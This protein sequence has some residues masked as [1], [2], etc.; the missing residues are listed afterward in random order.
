MKNR[1]KIKKINDSNELLGYLI[2][3]ADEDGDFNIE[4][5]IKEYGSSRLLDINEMLNE[6]QEKRYILICNRTVIHVY[7][8][9]YQEYISPLKY[10]FL[11][12]KTP[13][14]S[15]LNTIISSLIGAIV[16]SII[17]KHF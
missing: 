9:G 10:F 17:T 2:K 8:L 13:A 3:H 12:M 6:L 15:I 16:G 1:K 14:F 5:L 4:A 7:P 11:K